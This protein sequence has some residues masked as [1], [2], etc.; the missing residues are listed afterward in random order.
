MNIGQTVK[1]I[2]KKYPSVTISRLRFLEKEGLI[3][4][5]RSKGG[6]RNFSKKDIE[7]VLKIIS[8]QEDEFYS[9]RAIKNNQQLISNNK[10]KNIKIKEYSKHDA[11]KTSGLSDHN[12][13]DLVEFNFEIEKDKFSQ[14]D[15]DRL[16]AFGYFY[17]LGLT[18]KNF[19][20]IQSLS[21]RGLGFIETIK[22]IND[23][24]EDDL[25]IAINKF[26]LIIGSYILED[27]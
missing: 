11:L 13:N 9:L 7:R 23:I 22:N 16:S 21:D 20:L 25:E 14:N 6:T 15:V 5:K 24:K 12:F 26:S 27:S 10:S 3:N 19:S 1:E 4:P 8:L 18:A 17:N 2:Q